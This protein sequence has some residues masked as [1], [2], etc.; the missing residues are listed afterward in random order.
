MPFS[1]ELLEYS[2]MAAIILPDGIKSRH[3]KIGDVVDR[4]DLLILGSL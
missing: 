1:F 3:G 2:A 4:V